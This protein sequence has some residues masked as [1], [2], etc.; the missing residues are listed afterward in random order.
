MQTLHQPVLYQEIIHALLPKSGGRYVDGTLG[1]G[2]HAAG[3]LKN[4]EPAGLLLGMDVDPQ[5]IQLASQY[6]APFGER[7]RLI[8]AA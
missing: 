6:L 3:I 8:K 1:G 4:S 2:G 7:A 5:A